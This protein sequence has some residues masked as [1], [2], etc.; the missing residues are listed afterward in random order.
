MTLLS[1]QFAA[2]A[3]ADLTFTVPTE[4]R[5]WARARRNGKRYFKDAHTERVEYTIGTW[6]IQAMKGRKLFVGPVEL[7]VIS[8]LPVP[9]SWPALKRQAALSGELRPI[10]KPDFDNL[11][12]GCADAL[13][14]IV[15]VDDKQVVDGRSIKFYGAYPCIQVA[16][17]SAV[18]GSARVAPQGPTLELVSKR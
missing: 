12:K 18:S 6:A 17:R 4:P 9:P 15:Y 10:G 8:V 3:E 1:A 14:G 13:S 2:S 7:T 11:I 5:G 16:V